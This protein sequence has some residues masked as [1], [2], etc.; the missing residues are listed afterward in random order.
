M[1]LFVCL[2]H[3]LLLMRSAKGSDAR[4]TVLWNFRW[5]FLCSHP[6]QAVG[7]IKNLKNKKIRKGEM[8]AHVSS[9]NNTDKKKK[10][11]K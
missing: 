3:S 10:K 5:I 6:H 1:E 2:G 9:A 8:E 11:I 7:V 4:N